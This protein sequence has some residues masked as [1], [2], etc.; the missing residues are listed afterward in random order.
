MTASA[1]SVS[2]RSQQQHRTLQPQQ[3][4]R[5]IIGRRPRRRSSSRRHHH[6]IAD[7]SEARRDRERDDDDD[8]RE[9]SEDKNGHPRPGT[10]PSAGLH[11]PTIHARR[12]R[13]NGVRAR[14]W[15]GNQPTARAGGRAETCR[16]RRQWRRLVCEELEAGHDRLLDRSQISCFACGCGSCFLGACAW[17]HQGRACRYYYFTPINETIPRQTTHGET[18]TPSP[19]AIRP[20]AH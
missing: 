12:E 2:T 8:D 18:L 15:P 14:V 10:I 19:M 1:S 6:Q 3:L 5:A 11:Q 20:E 16:G 17:E 13:T 9:G 7:Y 4:R